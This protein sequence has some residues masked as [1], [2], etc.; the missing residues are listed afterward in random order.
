MKVNISKYLLSVEK[1]AQYL[2][3]E[4]NSCHKDTWTSNMCL[5]FPDIY[6]VG[7]SNLGIKILY[8]LMNKVPGFYLERGFMPMDDMED[9]M[10]K[11]NI[12]MFSLETKSELRDF[13][14]VGFSLSY[15][16][17]YPNMLNALSLGGIPLRREERGE[18]YP[19]IMAGGTCVMNPAPLEKFVDFL[20]VGD[21]EEN[22]PELARILVATKGKTKAEKLQAL[23]NLQGIY[24]PS[25][26]DKNKKVQRAIVRDLN[27]CDLY[28]EQLIPYMAIVH[29]RAT[30]EIQR[31]CTRGCRFCQ[32][33]IV[34]RPVRE[35]S[36]EKNIELVSKLIENTG[37]SE[38]SLSSLSSSDYTNIDSLISGIKS[39]YSCDSVG[40]SLPSLRMNPHSVKVAEII[41][42]GKRTGFTFAP[43]A[44]S[45]RMRDI[46][47]KGVTEDEIMATAEAAVRAGWMS[48]K[49]YFMIGLPFETMEDVQGIYEL[50]KKVSQMCRSIDKRINITASVSNFVPKPHTPFEWCK[51]MSMD[52]MVEKH[53]FLKGLFT[54]LKGVALKIHPPKKSLLEGLISRG[55]S[56]TGDLIELAFKK[57]VKLDDYRDN[58]NLWME[59]LNEL[60]LSVDYYLGERSFDETL[61]WDIIDIGVSKEFLRREYER[62]KAQ[63]LSHDC[64]LGCLGCGMKKIIPECGNIV[65]TK[66]DFSL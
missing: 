5:V 2:G 44:G 8:T 20:M 65:D 59:A 66:K 56:K 60:G 16:M 33:G 63:T 45:Q 27:K 54:G 51:Q 9:I 28:D 53:N 48:L 19:L 1:P 17:C 15:E 31:G 11:N 42:G 52:E 55:D 6:E 57:G 29:D 23:S 4:I 49:F 41:S 36:L 39:K 50:V 30:A 3:N 62:A 58:Y 22:M 12:P 47:N 40:V 10:R 24:I 61:P 64:R 13:D 35:R 32:A 7:M 37:H 34:Y 14:V 21:G 38:I 46:I 26:H 43:E 18:E 25:L